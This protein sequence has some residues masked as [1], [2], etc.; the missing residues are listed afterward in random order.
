MATTYIHLSDIHFGQE[1]GG[2]VVTHND[3]K[4][5]LIDDVRKVTGTLPEPRVDGVIISGDIAY[6]GK[7]D[8]YADAARWLDQLAA[9]AGCPITAIQVVPGNHDVDRTRVSH[10]I[11]QTLRNIA[12]Q[13][14]QEL[15]RVLV[16][17]E[18]RE[19]FYARFDGYRP[20]GEGYGCPLDFEGGNA[21]AR[22]VELAPNRVLRF[23]GLNT[24]LICGALKD[25]EGK[26]LLGARQRVL[27]ITA[28]EEL[29]LIAHHPLSWLQDS[30]DARRYVRNRA[31]VLITGHEHNPSARVEAV[32]DGCDVLMLAAGAT[33]PPHAD[34]R[35]TYTY[36]FL[37]FSWESPTDNLKV[38][39]QP[40]AWSDE[41]KE[42]VADTERLGGPTVE[43]VLGCPN[44]R[45]MAPPVTT[46]LER[47]DTA[48]AGSSP[49]NVPHVD[50]DTTTD[51]RGTPPVDD[52]F[53]IMRL[54]FFR[55]LSPAK[56]M[57][58]LVRLGALPEDWTEALTH[59]IEK[60]A[61]DKL[62]KSGRL[63]E[64]ERAIDEVQNKP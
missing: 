54:R 36:N 56:R 20:F 60:R 35:Y 10:I 22:T 11:G 39:V 17:P 27:P 43:Y 15:D 28:G 40:R 18:D 4:A 23:I 33:I 9:A 8:E 31:R 1:K 48:S 49:I 32:R 44:F 21:G 59:P 52:Q 62:R 47:R 38:T 46:P 57:E 58:V 34:E 6:A 5:R 64:L 13:G 51:A 26:L 14:E 30:D 50:P 29:V 12:D 61:L 53:A 37:Q 45:R 16:A 42:F 55:D 3:V 7:S 41:D 2:T 25:E 63:D 24:A 19:M